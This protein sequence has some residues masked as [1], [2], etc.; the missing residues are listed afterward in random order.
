MVDSLIAL[1]A[2]KPDPADAW[3]ALWRLYD[4]GNQ[5]HILLLTNQL[6]SMRMKE[7]SDVLTYLMEASN[8]RDHLATQLGQTITDQ[9]LTNIIL[10]RGSHTFS[11]LASIIG[12]VPCASLLLGACVWRSSHSPRI[13]RSRSPPSTLE[14]W[15]WR[16]FLGEVFILRLIEFTL[17]LLI[18]AALIFLRLRC[19]RLRYLG[20]TALLTSALLRV[21]PFSSFHSPC[22]PKKNGV[23]HILHAQGLPIGS[24]HH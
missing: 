19:L 1:V 4:T 21:N 8:L 3:D 18:P 24:P 17:W 7:G 2:G 23:S 9:Q 15:A 6:Y 5:Q 20:Y 22:S 11:I 13:S 12:E 16:S 14:N 10:N